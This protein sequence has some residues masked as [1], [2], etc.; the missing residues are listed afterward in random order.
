MT[1]YFLGPY[2]QAI[3]TELEKVETT[4]KFEDTD[5]VIHISS[6]EDSK[7]NVEVPAVQAKEKNFDVVTLRTV[8]R[9]AT[10]EIIDKVG[11]FVF[12]LPENLFPK[13]IRIILTRGHELLA[14]S[15]VGHS[16][17]YAVS[18]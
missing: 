18:R 8:P 1:K 2:T 15:D 14:T 3:R 4:T 9:D 13:E 10:P 17:F 6:I 16:L 5:T 7:H 12:E 11:K